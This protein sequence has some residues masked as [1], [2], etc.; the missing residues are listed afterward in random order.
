MSKLHEIEQFRDRS[1]REAYADEFL[2]I[3]VASQL[4]TI[5]EQRGLT[6]EE[7]A[8]A[9]GTKQGGISRI[10][11]VN[12]SG[13]NVTTLK[14]IA[15][16]LGCRLNISLETF[17]SLIDEEGSRCTREALQRPD[18]SEDPVFNRKKEGGAATLRF[19]PQKTSLGAGELPRLE[20]SGQ[21]PGGA[22]PIVAAPAAGA[23]PDGTETIERSGNGG[24]I[25]FTN[26]CRRDTGAG[27]RC[28]ANDGAS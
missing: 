3:Y 28:F 21:Y 15:F 19:S 5:R 22:S 24:N 25:Y 18:F 27:P 20:R 4:R 10:E 11:N 2:N 9:I 8:E 17:G 14:K 13:W 7:L 26:E 23:L 6:Q 16:A 12:Y 1:Y